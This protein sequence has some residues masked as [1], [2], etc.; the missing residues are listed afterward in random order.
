MRHCE[1]PSAAAEMAIAN[2]F[3]LDHVPGHLLTAQ[4]VRHLLLQPYIALTTVNTI[5]VAVFGSLIT[6][7]PRDSVEMTIHRP[8]SRSGL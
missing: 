3:T 6:R 1:E 7:D 2:Q 5:H 8:P 4:D